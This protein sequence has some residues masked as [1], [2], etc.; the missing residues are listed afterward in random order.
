LLLAAACLPLLGVLSCNKS[1]TK[2]TEPTP[3]ALL[4]VDSTLDTQLATELARIAPAVSASTRPVDSSPTA[5]TTR[6]TDAPIDALELYARGRD[7]LAR[8]QRASSISLL[9]QATALDPTSAELYR[10]LGE[11]HGQGKPGD[12][13]AIEALTRA[14]ELNSQDIH[15]QLLLVRNLISANRTGDAV[16]RL[17]DIT[18]LPDYHRRADLSVITDVLLA[19]ALEQ[20]GE[21]RAAVLAWRVLLPKLDL[22]GTFGVAPELA[23]LV[24]QPQ[25]VLGRVGQLQE[26]LGEHE[27]A[28]N[29]YRLAA[30]REPQDADWPV[31]SATAYLAAARYD[32]AIEMAVLASRSAASDAGVQSLLRQ[33]ATNENTSRQLIASLRKESVG[34]QDVS[35]SLN[36]VSVLDAAGMPTDADAEL[37][38]LATAHPANF[39]ILQA[40]FDRL[41]GAGKNAAAAETLVRFVAANPPRAQAVS[42]LLESL[43]RITRTPRLR[44]ADVQGLKVKP[45]E[46]TARQW[47]LAR[48][49]DR[50]ERTVVRDTAL[51][52]AVR[53]QPIIPDAFR[54]QFARL[55]SGQQAAGRPDAENA[56]AVTALIDAA[57]AGG[58]EKLARELAVR[59]LLLAGDAAGIVA[60]LKDNPPGDDE[61]HTR[62]ALAV[63]LRELGQNAEFE[64]TAFAVIAS[65]PNFDQAYDAIFSYYLQER[66]L[67]DAVTLTQRWI[68][69]VPDALR[70]RTMQVLLFT[71][72]DRLDLAEQPLRWM[73]A[74]HPDDPAVLGLATEY[75]RRAGRITAWMETLD[76]A[77]KSDPGNLEVVRFLVLLNLDQER[78]EQAKAIVSQTHALASGDADKLYLCSQ[79]YRMVDDEETALLAKEQAVAADP[80]HAPASNDLAYEWSERGIQLSR[81][82]ELSKMAVAA[83]PDNTAFL[84]TLGWVY[85]K[86]GKFDDAVEQLTRAAELD[87]RQEPVH[88]DHLGDA[89]YRLGKKDLAAARWK[90]AM[91]IA[92]RL[93]NQREDLANLRLQLSAKLRAVEAGQDVPVAPLPAG[94]T[95]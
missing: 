26:D 61:P 53:G 70:P 75:Y 42:P 87:D 24:Q 11:A 5:A 62:L 4:E 29:A 72:A 58:D 20:M 71:R 13:A 81:A 16:A 52:K 46:E 34:H 93:G 80:T 31:R 1:R 3:T 45:G 43:M 19:R 77:R 35:A 9:E 32:Q 74:A 57:R 76:Q 69:A 47:L 2:S 85:Y 39:S 27:Q 40:R 22:V 73:V 63:A 68:D 18:H 95:N 86:L 60:L 84:D 88:I 21:K 30:L 66:R 83:E 55:T 49:A 10:Q 41:A 37:A 92:V 14:S 33:L 36:L 6:P 15:I 67:G 25:L 12:P 7:L 38:R 79:F 59:R 78:L 90:Q 23:A 48:A 56:A 28:G 91:Q 44:V 17:R 65:D 64:K 51:D 8:G 82:L 54:D 89:L 94:T 50:N